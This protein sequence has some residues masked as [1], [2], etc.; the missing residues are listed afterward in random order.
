MKTF[1]FFNNHY[2][3]RH[4]KDQWTF[5]FVYKHKQQSVTLLSVLGVGGLWPKGNTHIQVR[6]SIGYRHNITDRDKWSIDNGARLWLIVTVHRPWIIELCYDWLQQSYLTSSVQTIPN[7]Q[8]HCSNFLTKAYDTRTLNLKTMQNS[9]L[10][11]R[12]TSPQ[13]TN[14]ALFPGKFHFHAL[15]SCAPYQSHP[16]SW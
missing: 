13:T 11:H 16:A 7:H 12:S 4:L 6:S 9:N 15:S 8:S 2:V 14:P 5:V 3:H 1:I 10:S